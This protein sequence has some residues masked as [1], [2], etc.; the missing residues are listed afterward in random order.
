MITTP[1][2]LSDTA[3]IAWV[4]VALLITLELISTTKYSNRRMKIAL[5]IPIAVLLYIFI[6]MILDKIVAVVR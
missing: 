3:S 2:D 5:I 4:L 6:W 1:I